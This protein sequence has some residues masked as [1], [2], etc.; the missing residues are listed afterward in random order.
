MHEIW[1]N[2]LKENNGEKLKNKERVETHT[3]NDQL[4][5][6]CIGKMYAKTCFFQ[7]YFI[8][9]RHIYT[10]Q[11]YFNLHTRLTLCSY[12]NIIIT[13]TAEYTHQSRSRVS[14][15]CRMLHFFHLI[16]FFFAVHLP[17]FP[18]CLV[19]GYC[20]YCCCCRSLPTFLFRLPRKDFD[21]KT[22]RNI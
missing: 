18:L 4:R 10:L 19:L 2:L 9:Y 1:R 7:K 21:V 16:P 22:R 11:F 12:L 15:F 5:L 17:F 13:S 6:L 3:H 20:R 8:Y 14:R